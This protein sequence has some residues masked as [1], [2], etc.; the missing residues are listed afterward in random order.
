MIDDAWDAGY[1]AELD[2]PGLLVYRSNLLGSDPRITNFG[3]GNTS[4]KIRET[5]PLTGEPVT[6]LWW[7]S[8]GHTHTGFVNE[9]FIDEV[10]H[11]AE[12]DP[13][14]YRRDL[15]TDHPRELAVLELAAA[16]GYE[17]LD[18]SERDPE[19][20]STYG[21]GELIRAARYRAESTNG[22]D[23]AGALDAYRGR[24]PATVE[25]KRKNG[26]M[27]VFELD[28][29]VLD[30]EQI[31]DKE[32]RLTLAMHSDGPSVRPDEVLGAIFGDASGELRLVREELLGGVTDKLVN[33]M[34]VP[35]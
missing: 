28:R 18:E 14:E 17:L 22:L 24:G 32:V 3:G 7:R 35:S 13:F 8:V 5:D 27:K 1:A 2:E 23:V 29:E 11:L 16:S 30:L 4:A 25:R 9:S 19:R 26:R 21:S 12:K 20:T 33:P 6:V 15:L 34:L 10:A 31:A